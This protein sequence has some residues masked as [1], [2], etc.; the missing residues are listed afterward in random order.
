M[1]DIKQ[2]VKQAA[3]FNDSPEQK[4]NRMTQLAL[5]EQIERVANAL[6]VFVICE[7]DL[8]EKDAPE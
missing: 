2:L 4:L 3:Q 8:K 6:K 5:A 7:C 1:I